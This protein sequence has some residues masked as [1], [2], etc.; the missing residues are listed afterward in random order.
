METG[1][2]EGPAG[3][4]MVNSLLRSIKNVN[5]RAGRGRKG[6]RAGTKWTWIN[7][8]MAAGWGNLLVRIFHS[9]HGD[10]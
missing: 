2:E 7:Y 9:H 1:G 10:F 6:L 8:K 4:T 5:K 3:G